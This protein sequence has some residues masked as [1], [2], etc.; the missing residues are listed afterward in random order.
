MLAVSFLKI[1]FEINAAPMVDA[2]PSLKVLFWNRWMIDDFPTDD[3]PRKTSF[4][5]AILDGWH[6]RKTEV[7]LLLG[8]LEIED[9]CV[10]IV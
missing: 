7:A 1:F 3:S 10:K 2:F 6:V 4:K 9:I 5:S 8:R